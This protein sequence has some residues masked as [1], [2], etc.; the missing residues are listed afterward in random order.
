MLKEA[1]DEVRSVS[2]SEKPLLIGV[3]ILTSMSAEEMGELG[4]AGNVREEVL[5][6]AKLAKEVGLDGVVASAQ[7][8]RMIKQEIGED[9]LVVTPGVR[10][11]WSLSEKEDQKR[12]LTPK[13]AVLEGADFLVIGRPI[14]KSDDPLEAANRVILELEE[15]VVE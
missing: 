13:Q 11:L 1:V 6:L 9:F 8:A 12:V 5:R 15:I 10:P 14:I 4:I 2:G 7:E 3:T